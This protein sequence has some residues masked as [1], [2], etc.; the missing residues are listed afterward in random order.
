MN[1]FIR[2]DASV[3]IG[4]GHVMRCLTLAKDL[5]MKGA[6]VT[7]ICR[8]LTG[9]L[10]NYIEEQGFEVNSLPQPNESNF[11][12]DSMIKHSHWLK[13]YWKIDMNQTKNILKKEPQIDWLIVD[14]YA[15]DKK[16]EREMRPLVRK[17][18]VIDDL[19]D[20][21]HDCDLLLDQN[22][23]LDKRYDKFVPKTSLKLLGP[24]YALL[25]QE[26]RDARKQ[27][28]FRD[29]NIKCILIFFGGSDS[30]NETIKTLEAIK[31]LDKK[32][33]KVDV[34]V[35]STNKNKEQIK[36]FCEDLPN[37]IFHCQIDYIAQLM[38]KADLSI[39][40]GGSSTWERCYLGLPT[41]TIETA[42]NQAEIISILD[43]IGVISHLGKSHDVRTEDIVEKL[44]YL[45]NNSDDLKR[46]SNS[47]L[48]VMGDESIENVVVQYILG[49]NMSKL[50]KYTLQDMKEDNLELV[51]KWRNSKTIR[52][53]MY[54][55]HIITMTE[56][57]EWFKKLAN[58]DSTIVKIFLS[59][60]KPLGLVNISK[61]DKKNNK[62]YWGF[63]IGEQD[64][65]LGSG[66]IMGI[67]ALEFIFE[68]LGI[69]KICS[70][71][72]EY[73]NAS[74][75]YHKKLGFIEEGRFVKHLIKND[76]YIDVILM[77]HFS[78][79]WADGKKDLLLI[80][81]IDHD[82]N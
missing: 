61:I 6:R 31:L 57:K 10:L 12:I 77:A 34:V 63:Y 30:T 2:T 22:I 20:R 35:G 81:G 60:S 76:Q 16:W 62:C 53:S 71:I 59:E 43:N 33:I 58:D 5:K 25:R 32:N 69:R 79:K 46:I 51:L 7:F 41:L 65:P 36:L 40:A 37:T 67:L 3:E 27:L 72:L 56:H 45:L 55:D 15:I 64:A 42:N 66:T 18:M 26:F 24:K 39:G 73:N 68:K 44:E 19:A 70:E 8:K 21:F 52:S 4:T 29:G 54:T 38:L 80:G 14:H 47:S 28:R 74:L 11:K 9:N 75:R 48:C 82:R 49:G 50:Q 17:I 78:E 1:I 13:V 23:Q